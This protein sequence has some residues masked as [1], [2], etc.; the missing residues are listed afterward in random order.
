MEHQVVIQLGEG[1][2]QLGFPSV[3][4][5][6]W[7]RDRSAGQVEQTR[8]RLP[9]APHIQDLFQRWQQEYTALNANLGLRNPTQVMEIEIVSNDITHISDVKFD[10]LCNDLKQQFNTWIHG[11]SFLG[12]DQSLRRYLDPNSQI[13]VVIEA[14][15]PG[16]RR[17]PWHLWNFFEDYPHAEVALSNLEYRKVQPTARQI[18]EQVRILSILGDTTGIQV[19]KDRATLE[20]LGDT[21]IHFLQEPSREEFDEHLWDETGW[22]ILFFAGHSSSQPGEQTG[23]M[24]INATENVSISQLRIALKTAI[25]NGLQLAIFNSCE[26]MGL[27]R[28]LA[29]LHIPYLIVMREPVPDQV[30]QQFLTNFLRAF[31]RGNP[32]PLAV[33]EARERLYG[34][35]NKFPCAS[36]LPVICQN[37]TAQTLSWPSLKKQTTQKVL[38]VNRT[39]PHPSQISWPI[40]QLRNSSQ[41]RRVSLKTTLLITLFTTLGVMAIRL[42]GIFQ[43]IELSAYDHLMR[44]RPLEPRD[45]RVLIVE[46]TTDDF[47]RYGGYPLPDKVLTE[48]IEKIESYKPAAI[49]LDMHRAQPKGTVKERAELV[50]QFQ[51][52]PNL[53]TVC[54]YGSRLNDFKP[55]T[56]LTQSDANSSLGFSNLGSDKTLDEV[57]RR[58]VL[59][60]DPNRAKPTNKC[61]N[62]SLSLLLADLYLTHHKLA[63][64]K[65]D[66][67]LYMG[68][69]IIEQLFN[70]FV[71][72]QALGNK[73]QMMIDYRSHNSDIPP[74]RKVPVY[75]V[76][77]DQVNTYSIKDKIVLIG[78]N[79]SELGDLHKTP[80]GIKPGVEIHAHVISQLLDNAVHRKRR[81]WG[82]P[83]WK[84]IQWGDTI[85]VLGWSLLSSLFMWQIRSSLKLILMMLFVASALYLACLLMFLIGGWM[86]LWPSIFT[87]VITAV[88]LNIPFGTLFNQFSKRTLG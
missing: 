83:Q 40:N 66:Q 14:E 16:V 59:F 20:N 76:L 44:L 75:Q 31:S 54:L 12:V 52:Y 88:A 15:D 50:K 21:D 3:I 82:L 25:R 38:E 65:I 17:F 42:L 70:R 19:E 27:A 84:F 43:P 22:D 87:M 7:G 39:Q 56:E 32:F 81:I 24:Q 74:F 34:L 9:A 68:D 57:I 1:S 73:Y 63:S 29:G 80:Y 6:I 60:F 78:T 86:P 35:E 10:D 26:G 77:S 36:W 69:T 71:G 18:H 49:G 13:Q 61:P 58:Q 85:W 41:S 37:P 67:K 47:N 5:Q 45:P 51:T 8:G 55:P 2:W 53:L 62:F 23:H 4:V 30:A 48:L 46:T 11:P 33:K 28:E 64:V 79:A 72:Y